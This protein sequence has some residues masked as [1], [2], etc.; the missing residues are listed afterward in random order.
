MIKILVI[1]AILAIVYWVLRSYGR[2]LS[3]RPATP[4]G[5]DMVRCVQCGVHLPKSESL[6]VQGNFFC[7]EA[8]RRLHQQDERRG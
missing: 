5:E 3:K 2:S 4:A 8:H 6:T 7:S 1:I